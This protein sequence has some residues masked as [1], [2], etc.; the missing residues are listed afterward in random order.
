MERNIVGVMILPRPA[1]FVVERRPHQPQ[2][3][4]A[5]KLEIR[6]LKAVPDPIRM[7]Q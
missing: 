5:G 7:M 6:V 2:Q 4:I 3:I 1:L